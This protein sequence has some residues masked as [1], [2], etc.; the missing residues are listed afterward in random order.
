[1]KNIIKQGL[2]GP[3]HLVGNS[4]RVVKAEISIFPWM[5]CLLIFLFFPSDIYLYNLI[6]YP[7]DGFVVST[8]C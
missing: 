3:R 8:T 1:M 7:V 4:S 2:A 5:L 6:C